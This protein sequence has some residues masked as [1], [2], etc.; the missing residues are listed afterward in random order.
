MKV[1]EYD[2]S[3]DVSHY[4]WRRLPVALIIGVVVGM[5]V[6]ILAFDPLLRF[7]SRGAHLNVTE[8][9]E[10]FWFWIRFAMVFGVSSGMVGCGGAIM[11]PSWQSVR[12]SYA[13]FCGIFVV[14]AALGLLHAYR[15]WNPVGLPFVSMTSAPMLAAPVS[16][17]VAVM[18][19][20]GIASARRVAA[21]RGGA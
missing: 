11:A 9:D 10:P 19:G 6:G 12:I 4:A 17:C 21:L 16:G 8:A 15:H 3:P 7:L 5:G 1:L 2:R 20:C 13:A 18:L 14:G